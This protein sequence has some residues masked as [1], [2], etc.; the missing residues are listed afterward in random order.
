M[1]TIRYRST[2]K[3]KL[4]DFISDLANSNPVQMPPDDLQLLVNS[5]ETEL[6]KLLDSHTSL[7]SKTIVEHHGSKWFTGE[8]GKLKSRGRAI[9]QNSKTKWLTVHKLLH[10]AKAG[11]YERAC[12]QTKQVY[13]M[14][15]VIDCNWDHGSMF[16]I[17]NTVLHRSSASPL[18]SSESQTELAKAFCEFFDSKIIK[19]HDNLSHATHDVNVR[20]SEPTTDHAFSEFALVTEESL[21]EIIRR[22]PVM[23][24]TF[25]PDPCEITQIHPTNP[26]ADHCQNC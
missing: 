5:Y 6:S 7:H 8:L 24:W 23:S 4:P 13:Y 18:P 1:K 25:E 16:S 14:N 19:I 10:K 20:F 17:I 22:S 2:V 11:E 15:A 12:C 9:D 21:D 3:I 26:S